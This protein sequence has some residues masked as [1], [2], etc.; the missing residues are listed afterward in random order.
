M[1]IVYATVAIHPT[2]HHISQRLIQTFLQFVKDDTLLILTDDANFYQQYSQHS[3]IIILED[4]SIQTGI[5]S[6]NLNIKYK[7]LQ[8]ANTYNPTHIVLFDCDAYFTQLIDNNWF[9]TLPEG[10]SVCVGD[11]LPAHKI[12][13]P[14]IRSKVLG[15][16]PDVNKIYK[17]FREGAFIL[18]VN[19]NFLK[20][21]QAWEELYYEALTK[22]LT[23][24]SEVFEINLASERSNFPIIN[25]KHNP[26]KDCIWMYERL[27]GGREA[28]AVA[29]R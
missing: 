16:N 3:N 17:M 23:H 18:T 2:Y 6:V 28:I 24:T 25:L 9:S 11:E 21:T 10:I 15:F 19:F 20:F 14:T 12:Q 8:I 7:L 22:H 4:K 26:I 1:N 29:L 13:N 27:G 5:P